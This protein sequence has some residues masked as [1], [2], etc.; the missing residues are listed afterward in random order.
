MS[1]K[2]TCECLTASGSKCTRPREMKNGN[3]LYCWQHRKCQRPANG[4]PTTKEA[5][6]STP[7]AKPSPPK[8]PAPVPK[9]SPPKTPAPAPAPKPSPPKT[10]APAPAPKPSPPKAPVTQPTSTPA[11]VPK[12]SPPKTPAPTP[13]PA[14]KPSPPKAPTAPIIQPAPAPAPKP[15]PP[16][17]PTAPIIQPTPSPAPAPVQ[18]PSVV[19]PA[20]PRGPPRAASPRAAPKPLPKP[21][22][23]RGFSKLQLEDHQDVLPESIQVGEKQYPVSP[24]DTRLAYIP[25]LKSL[26]TET[27]LEQKIGGHVPIFFEGE[28]WPTGPSGQPMEFIMQFVDPR[29]NKNDL[30]RVFI[31]DEDGDIFAKL[32]LTSLNTPVTVIPAASVAEPANV[33]HIS[34]TYNVPKQIVGWDVYNEVSGQFIV[35]ILED[36]GI[37]GGEEYNTVFDN[38]LELVSPRENRGV[39]KI[40]GFGESAQSLTYEDFIHNIYDTEWGDS[41]TIHITEDGKAEG[42]MA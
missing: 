9:P 7:V 34:Q 11:P 1:E 30:V 22:S 3:D 32:L 38:I 27:G 41:G 17:T 25:R 19:R 37:T 5:P 4:V 18:R 36:F 20:S 14:P 24:E 10:S 42:D 40:G 29:P 8:T 12:P 39:I 35:N 26:A 23:D 21:L 13:A 31:I 6:V 33:K 2:L 28:S 16:K 15:S